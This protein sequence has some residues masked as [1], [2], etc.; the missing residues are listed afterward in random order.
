MKGDD[1]NDTR[2]LKKMANQAR[3]YLL[4]FEWC[5]KIEKD[6]FGWG[7]GGVCAVFLFQ[8]LPSKRKVDRWLWVIVG[9]LP[10]AHLVVD[11][12]PTPLEALETYLE[13][14]QEWANAVKSGKPAADCIPVNAPATPKNADLLQRRL[15]FIRKQF[16]R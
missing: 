9:D 1:A 7:V 3:E 2:L 10:S 8:I 16:L 11:E 15:D 14:M 13:L 4:S 6:W 12:S 5:K